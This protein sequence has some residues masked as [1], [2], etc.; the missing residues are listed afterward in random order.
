MMQTLTRTELAWIY[1][2]LAREAHRNAIIMA[3]NSPDS[4]EYKLANIERE[5]AKSVMRKI[6]T[7]RND[8]S[9]RIKVD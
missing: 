9:K 4:I 7:I 8:S 1:T 6:Q 5:N 2:A 3:N